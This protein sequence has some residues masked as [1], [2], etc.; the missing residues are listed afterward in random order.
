MSRTKW[1]SGVIHR[2]EK[3]VEARRGVTLVLTG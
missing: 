2:F 3:F 1:A